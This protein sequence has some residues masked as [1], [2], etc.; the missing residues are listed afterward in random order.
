[1]T[2][3]KKGKKKHHHHGRSLKR[4]ARNILRR[5]GLPVPSF[6]SRGHHHN[7]NQ[8]LSS[9]PRVWTSA[10]YPLLNYP[11]SSSLIYTPSAS[12]GGE[13]YV[14][15]LDED[16]FEKDPTSGKGVKAWH[17]FS[18]GGEV[19]GKLV[20]ASKGSPEDFAELARR[21]ASCLPL[22]LSFY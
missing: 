19:E 14:A 3:E 11:L 22:L 4:S 8:K 2:G 16:V 7:T 18:A 17:G 15:N 9:T 10:Y 20:Y 5:A 6:L 1:M 13:P 21:G 12:E